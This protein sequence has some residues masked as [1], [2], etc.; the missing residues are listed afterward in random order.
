MFII[1]FI[2]SHRHHHYTRNTITHIYRTYKFHP[3]SP[4]VVAAATAVDLHTSSHHQ[5]AGAANGASEPPRHEASGAVLAQHGGP[6]HDPGHA[7]HTVWRLTTLCLLYAGGQTAG[8][9]SAAPR[10]GQHRARA[11]SSVQRGHP[12]HGALSAD[13]GFAGRDAE[14][15]L[16]RLGDEEKRKKRRWPLVTM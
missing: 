7:A 15:L 1:H 2:S 11:G 14:R 5:R 9:G 10:R 16:E 8:D 4:T 13:H 3:H 6:P 12:A